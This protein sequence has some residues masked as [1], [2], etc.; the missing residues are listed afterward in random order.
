MNDQ[1]L[2]RLLEQIQQSSSQTP[3]YLAKKII[4][5][6]PE[7]TPLD[8]MLDFLTA[9]IWRPLATAALPLLIGFTLGVSGEPGG[10]P[11][12]QIWFEAESILFAESYEEYTNDEI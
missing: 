5:N 3:E 8:R 11:E 6:L 1:E 7:R 10:Q 2:N 4:A 9:N 12:T